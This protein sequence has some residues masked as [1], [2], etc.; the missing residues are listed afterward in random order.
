MHGKI[1]VYIITVFLFSNAFMTMAWYGQNFGKA[2]ETPGRIGW[3]IIRPGT[4][5]F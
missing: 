4:C 1:F 3:Y 5:F 2:G